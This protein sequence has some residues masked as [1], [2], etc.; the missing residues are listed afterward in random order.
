MQG[1]YGHIDDVDLSIYRGAYQLKD[2]YLD[3]KSE[4]TGKR[5]EFLKIKIMDLSIQWG[6]LIHGKLVGE[7]NAES[8]KLIFTRHKVELGDVK[9]DTN[10]FRK[11]LD[12]FMPLK[13]NRFTVNNGDLHYVDENSKP[14]VD[15][16]L[17][18]IHML[19]ENLNNVADSSV[20][21]P[22][23]VTAHGKA[24]EGTLDLNMKLNPLAPKATFDL[25]AELKNT[26]LPLLN[27]FLK[28]Y[29]GFDVNKGNFGLYTE[30]A[31]KDGKF[32]GYV[33][34]VIKDLK[35]L[36]PQDK[37]DN[38]FQKLWEGIVGAAGMVFKN[39][40]KNQIATKVPMEGD[41]SDPKTN[42]LEAIWEVLKNAFIQALMPNV[43]NQININ[44]VDTNKKKDD[45]NLLQKIF[46]SG[47]KENDKKG[48]DKKEGKK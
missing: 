19:A 21:L 30:M 28:A 36:G 35:V 11:A 24:Y 40:N 9:K 22:A 13:I 37:K 20:L 26:R 45:R 6:A 1:Y 10:D 47:K 23:K 15:I 34:P 38:I 41:F 33:K 25:N 3:K 29:G 4:R 14:K 16:A 2:M 7:V 17:K 8:P 44:S 5:T 46:S 32:K 12:R 42:T 48:T 39:Q 18:D 27:D 43:D 31:A